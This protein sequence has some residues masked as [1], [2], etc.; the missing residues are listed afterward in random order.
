MEN[1]NI[2]M[3]CE[4][5]F[6]DWEKELIEHLKPRLP[7]IRNIIESLEKQ[8]DDDDRTARLLACDISLRFMKFMETMSEDLN[9]MADGNLQNDIH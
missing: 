8:L 4:K 3:E 2:K 9:K 5:E 1:E 6:L 7:K